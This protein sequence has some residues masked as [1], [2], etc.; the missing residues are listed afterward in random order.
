MKAHHLPLEHPLATVTDA[1]GKFEIMNAPMGKYQLL[2]WHEEVGF[3]TQP[4]LKGRKIRGS[5]IE[6]KRKG[7]TDV[8]KI[9]MKEVEE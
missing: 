8:G 9:G 1:D 2:L 5:V 6:I 7:V 3:L 4:N